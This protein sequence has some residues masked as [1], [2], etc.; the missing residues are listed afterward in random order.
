MDQVHV[1]I[2]NYYIYLK[3]KNKKLFVILGIIA[4]PVFLIP[5]MYFL[6]QL[7][8]VGASCNGSLPPDAHMN[9]ERYIF[10]ISIKNPSLVCTSNAQPDSRGLIPVGSGG[11]CQ[12]K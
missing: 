7:S 2:N 12:Y 6:L 4:I 1:S 9:C 8:L 3:M 10:G 11:T 5:L